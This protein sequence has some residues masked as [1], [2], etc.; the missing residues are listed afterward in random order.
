MPGGARCFCGTNLASEV[1]RYHDSD[2]NRATSSARLCAPTLANSAETWTSTVL[3]EQA[4]ASA[5]AL[6]V[7]PRASQARTSDCRGVRPQRRVAS[8]RRIERSSWWVWR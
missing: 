7:A 5:M 8:E 1:E 3:F 6:L 4:R 2:Q